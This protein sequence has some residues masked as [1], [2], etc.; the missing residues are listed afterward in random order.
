MSVQHQSMTS[1]SW[2][3]RCRSRCYM[4]TREGWRHVGRGWNQGRTRRGWRCGTAEQRVV[5]EN[6]A[7]ARMSVQVKLFIALH[8]GPFYRALITTSII[9]L[10]PLCSYSVHIQEEAEIHLPLNHVLSVYF[11]AVTLDI[12]QSLCQKYDLILLSWF[13]S[14]FKTSHVPH[15]GFYTIF[16]Y[17]SRKCLQIVET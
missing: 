16:W 12:F 6:G 8:H 7:R 2:Q 9:P 17:P 1:A 15:S 14:F 10:F 5:Q 3:R 4:G 13:F 11:W